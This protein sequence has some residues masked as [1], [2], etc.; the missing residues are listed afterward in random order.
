MATETTATLT[1]EQLRTA[2][3][4]VEHV[5]S[6]SRENIFATL[7]IHT[8]EDCKPVVDEVERLRDIID[9]LSEWRDDLEQENRRLKA[10]LLHIHSTVDGGWM[11]LDT[12]TREY[13]V[14][15]ADNQ[16]WAEWFGGEVPR[17]EI[18]K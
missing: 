11:R 2:R 4:R 14:L 7:A 1:D 15:Q 16:E 3:L 12:P 9:G 13:W 10:M 18:G 5:L 6:L 8:A 17:K